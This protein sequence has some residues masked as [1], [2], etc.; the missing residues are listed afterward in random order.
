VEGHLASFIFKGEVVVKEFVGEKNVEANQAVIKKIGPRALGPIRGR[1]GDTYSYG[2]IRAVVS[3]FKYVN[4]TSF[5][6]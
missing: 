4:K 2:E 1:L 6:S 3:H 5:G